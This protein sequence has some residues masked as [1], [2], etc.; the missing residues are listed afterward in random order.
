M[1]YTA[2]TMVLIG[3]L[4]AVPGAKAEQWPV[5]ES[6]PAS[7]AAD[8]RTGIR[9]DRLSPRKLRI[10]KA[11]EGI[12][13]A[14]DGSG[15]RRYPKLHR[16]WQW[17]ETCGHVVQVELRDPRA[18]SDSQTGRFVVEKFDPDGQR[19][20]AVIRLCIPLIDRAPVR[21]SGGSDVGFTRFEG[22]SKE[23]RYA[24]V[25]GHELAHAVWVLGDE[26]HTGLM[27]NLKREIEEYGSLRR[28]AVSGTASWD[29][30]R[31]QLKRIGSLVSRIEKP[32]ETVEK[33]IWQELLRSRRRNSGLTVPVIDK[34]GRAQPFE[35]VLIS[36][37]DGS[38]AP[39]ELLA[40]ILSSH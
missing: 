35:E 27:K 25:L 11:I 28:H 12:V 20:L 34:G 22:L 29:Q 40:S 1:L 19:H 38:V 9:S 21:K 36:D 31:Q 16:L 17:V 32:A 26:S 4:L 24:E 5:E 8:L 33:E 39:G 10:W 14:R 13:L 30:T 15:Q 18:R 2:R 6:S 3:I 7:R 37:F 23:E